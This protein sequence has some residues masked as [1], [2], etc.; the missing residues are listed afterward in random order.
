M[1][2]IQCLKYIVSGWGISQEILC[3]EFIQGS[4]WYENF[5]W[6]NTC[7][8]LQVELSYFRNPYFR[9][10]SLREF[11][12]ALSIV[13]TSLQLR[14]RRI[15]S[16]ERIF[17]CINFNYIPHFSREQCEKGSVRQLVRDAAKYNILTS[18]I[19]NPRYVSLF[20]SGRYIQS[21]S[22]TVC[23]K[24]YMNKSS[25]FLRKTRLQLTSSYS[26]SRILVFAL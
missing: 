12:V 20:F 16:C 13:N 5:G 1:S 23:L 21:V 7:Q 10:Y 18:C 6:R 19:E 24:L 15:V 3:E 25:V 17:E 26:W 4:F 9:F 8:S 11:F 22:A 2:Y 14:V